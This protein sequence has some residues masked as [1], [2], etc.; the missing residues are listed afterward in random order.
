MQYAPGHPQYSQAVP[1]P[2]PYG[3]P[4]PGALPRANPNANPY[5]ELL[6][7]SALPPPMSHAAVAS[8]SPYGELIQPAALASAGV[9]RGPVAPPAPLALTAPQPY[10]MAA[11]SPFASSAPAM[12]PMSKPAQPQQTVSP[13]GKPMDET[14][15]T[16]KGKILLARI[17]NWQRWQFRFALTMTICIAGYCIFGIAAST[18]P[19]SKSNFFAFADPSKFPAAVGDGCGNGAGVDLNQFVVLQGTGTS[20]SQQFSGYSNCGFVYWD[21]CTATDGVLERT[22]RTCV[23]FNG[24]Y[25][26][27]SDFDYNQFRNLLPVFVITLLT[28]LV[29]APLDSFEHKKIL[30]SPFYFNRVSLGL[31]VLM[32]VIFLALNLASTITISQAGNSA[33]CTPHVQDYTQPC[34]YSSWSP[35]QTIL[36][37]AS[38]LLFGVWICGLIAFLLA[39]MTFFVALFVARLKTSYLLVEQRPLDFMSRMVKCALCVSAS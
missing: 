34:S 7:P 28:Q 3:G 26:K 24:Q 8:A 37:A 16:E 20:S 33:I 1:A 15:T 14:P 32:Q 2:S 12:S 30:T 36:S 27:L 29:L 9:P 39:F 18:T 21:T 6:P 35:G 25:V 38:G 17:C 23:V 31:R 4:G 5:G 11:Q 19:F 22:L 13:F 10:P